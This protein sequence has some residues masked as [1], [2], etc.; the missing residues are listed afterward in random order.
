[1]SHFRSPEGNKNADTWDLSQ[2]GSN[3]IGQEWDPAIKISKRSLIGADIHQVS[4]TSHW[5]DIYF[6]M[7]QKWF[8]MDTQYGAERGNTKGKPSQQVRGK[9]KSERRLQYFFF[10]NFSTFT[11]IGGDATVMSKSSQGTWDNREL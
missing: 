4:K 1:M 8:Q 2:T 10:F 6:E 5:G 11:V 3:L 9:Q 7:S